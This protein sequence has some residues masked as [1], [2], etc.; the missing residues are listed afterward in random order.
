M[1]ELEVIEEDLR[2][3]IFGPPITISIPEK[4]PLDVDKAN[5]TADEDHRISNSKTGWNL[6]ELHSDVQW[7]HSGWRKRRTKLLRALNSTS[8]LARYNRVSTCGDKA[9]VYRNNDTGEIRIQASHCHD[10]LCLPCATARAKTIALNIEAKLNT[11]TTGRQLYHV[12][13]TLQHNS[14]PLAQQ[15]DDLNRYWTKLRYTKLWKESVNGGFSTVEVTRNNQ[16]QWHPHL[17]LIVEAKRTLHAADLAAQWQKITSTSHVVDVSTIDN[18]SRAA[19]VLS[20]YV[21]KPLSPSI[22]YSPKALEEYVLATAGRKTVSTF[23]SWRG[24]SL[25]TPDR[26][27]IND[28]DWHCLG[29]LGHV[30]AKGLYDRGLKYVYRQLD[31]MRTVLTRPPPQPYTGESL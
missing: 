30:L 21:A 17:H 8:Q 1:P 16:G 26:D 29:S 7:R 19:Y 10:K 20:R 9:Y 5:T 28:N 31:A 25:T 12:V 22:F 13:L 18:T 4:A 6:G 27:P 24:L 3:D 11:K 15:L 14:N 2:D 23:G